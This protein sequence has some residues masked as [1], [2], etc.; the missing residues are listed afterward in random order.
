MCTSTKFTDR[1]QMKPINKKNLQLL[2]VRLARACTCSFWFP[3]LADMQLHLFIPYGCHLYPFRK[4]SVYGLSNLAKIMYLRRLRSSK[5][6]KVI[7]F[8]DH[9]LACLHVAHVPHVCVFQLQTHHVSNMEKMRMWLS[10][11][12]AGRAGFVGKIFAHW[13]WILEIW[14]ICTQTEMN[15]KAPHHIYHNLFWSFHFHFFFFNRFGW[16]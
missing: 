13:V 4:F 16:P 8:L 2:F 15:P 7:S 3:T 1:F 5:Y 12:R 10:T 14:K 9:P 6:G 11:G